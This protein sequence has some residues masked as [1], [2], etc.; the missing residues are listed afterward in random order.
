MVSCPYPYLLCPYI[1]V[2]IT[3]TWHNQFKI[4][5]ILY[6]PDFFLYPSAS[7]PPHRIASQLIRDEDTRMM[8][9]EE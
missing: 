9:E 3:F 1:I 5:L 4:I 8:M 7:T 6:F 2:N